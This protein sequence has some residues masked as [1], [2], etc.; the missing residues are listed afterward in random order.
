MNEPVQKQTVLIVDD[1]PTNIQVLMETLK[2]DYRILAA[3]TGQRALKLAASDPPPD[4]ILL[5][6]MMPDMDGY[7]VCSRLKADAKTRDIPIIFITAKSETQDETRGLELGAVDYITKPISPPVVQ[8][9]VK[10]HLELKAAREF[11]KN[12]NVILEQRVEER[13]REV[14]KLQQVE[15][16]LRAAKEKVENELNI[17]AQ[18]QKHIL[19]S[20]F[21]AYPDRN[22][23]DLFALMQP[24]LY[25]GGDFYDFFFVDDD[26]LAMVIADVS[27]KGIPAAMFMMVSRTLINSLAVDHSSPSIVLA[28]A[29][30]VLCQNNEAGMFVTVFLAFYEVSSGKL[31]ATNAGHSAALLVDSDGSSSEWASTH[32]AALGF[33]EDLSYKEETVELEAGQ[34]LFLYTDGVTEA[35]SS[36]EQLFGLDKLRGILEEKRS[37]SLDKLCRDIQARLTEFQRGRQFDDITMLA[38][39]RLR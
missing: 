2:D 33:M 37:F 5:D 22:E 15:F 29:N 30:N 4:I 7:E 28:K 12:Q 11:L 19:P 18:I 1:T 13:T 39:K 3:V 31:T 21:P 26:T 20:R 32:G 8:A 14:L 27:D 34:T 36:A 24:A 25:V 38:L 10:G 9:R 6:V 16:D 35:T 23:F 17:A